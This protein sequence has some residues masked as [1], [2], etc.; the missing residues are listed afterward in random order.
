MPGSWLRKIGI[1]TM[2]AAPRNEPRIEPS[3]PMMTMNRIWNERLMSKASGS[4]EPSRRNAHSAP[5]TPM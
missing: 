4:Q 2:K 3:P 5:A 1:S